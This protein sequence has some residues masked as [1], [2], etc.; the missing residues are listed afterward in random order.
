MGTINIIN[1][2]KERY[3]D[4][5]QINNYMICDHCGGQINKEDGCLE[6]LSRISDGQCHGLRL[7]HD[8]VACGYKEKNYP[9][10]TTLSIPLLVDGK[11]EGEAEADTFMRLLTWI[12]LG[13]L[14]ITEVLEMLKRLF[15][16]LYEETRNFFEQAI[17][18]GVF[19][20][21]TPPGFHWQVDL[22]DVLEYI[23][24]RA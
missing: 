10:Y 4:K 14:P 22:K 23:R 16:P 7:V 13:F 5:M 15:I 24:R 19:E 3:E 6:W 21:N 17:R 12:S 20:P 11:A 8:T 18:D 2:Y 9:G 1:L